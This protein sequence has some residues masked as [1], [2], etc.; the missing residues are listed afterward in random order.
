MNETTLRTLADLE[1]KQQFVL[2][3][4]GAGGFGAPVPVTPEADGTLRGGQ[5]LVKWFPTEFSQLRLAYERQDPEEGTA[6]DRLIFQTT[7]AL[8]PH[9][10]HAF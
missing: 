5:L 1:D 8:G 9:R 2:R 10:P 7:F 3:T 6:L 4:V